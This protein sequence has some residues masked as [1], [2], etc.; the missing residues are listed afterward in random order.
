MHYNGILTNAWLNCLAKKAQAFN[1]L[2]VLHRCGFAQKCKKRLYVFHTTSNCQATLFE[3]HRF[4]TY[5]QKTGVHLN[6]KKNKQQDRRMKIIVK[7]LQACPWNLLSQERYFKMSCHGNDTAV[8]METVTVT[9]MLM[10]CQVWKMPLLMP[11][12]T[13]VTVVEAILVTEDKR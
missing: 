12:V 6:S 13:V 11:L 8:P 5:Y 7:Y 4:S 2:S 1:R 9:L 10:S 3:S